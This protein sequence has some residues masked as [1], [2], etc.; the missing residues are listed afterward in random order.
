MNI[1]DPITEEQL[2]ALL[3]NE[4]DAKERARVLDAIRHDNEVSAQ[5][6]KLRQLKEMVTVAYLEPPVPEEHV[7][8]VEF[9]GPRN[10]TLKMWSTAAVLAL[11]LLGGISGWLFKSSYDSFTKPAFNTIAK[12]DLTNLDRDKILM[13]VSTLEDTRIRLLLD[14]LDKVLAANQNRNLEI[15]VVANSYGLGLLR[16]ESPYAQ[17]LQALK[18]KYNNNVS[19]LAC[20][21]SIE[22]TQIREG[23]KVQLLPAAQR[24][25]AA[26][27]RIFARLQDGWMY[28]RS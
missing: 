14:A 2:N 9:S 23:K 8:H 6:C 19:F 3:D 10:N 18:V 7:E 11:L 13:H 27:E 28:V 12:L 1:T 4:L 24:I 21:M 20:G 16:T 22:N 26:M 25:P 17:Q 15:E 5:Y